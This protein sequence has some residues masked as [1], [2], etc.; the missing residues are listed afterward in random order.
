MLQLL[1]QEDA[2]KNATTLHRAGYGPGAIPQLAFPGRLA[3]CDSTAFA[4]GPAWRRGALQ[5][6]GKKGVEK[7]EGEGDVLVDRPEAVQQLTHRQDASNVTNPPHRAGYYW[8]RYDFTALAGTLAWRR[9]VPQ[10]PR[11]CMP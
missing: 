5:L 6:L 10:G 2:P 4:G 3:E 7:R 11:R 8:P 1:H 9:G